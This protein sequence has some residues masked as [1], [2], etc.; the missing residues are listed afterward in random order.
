MVNQGK[1]LS[2][3]H[4]RKRIYEKLEPYPH[5]DKFKR[6]FDKFM[7]VIV[8]VAPLTNIPQLLTVWVDKNATGVSPLSWVLFSI[9]SLIWFFYGILHKDKHIIIMSA[10]LAVIQTLVAVGAVWYG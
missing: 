10:A 3:L 9:V 5:P 4:L 7:Y 2:H 6:N 1:G 8:I